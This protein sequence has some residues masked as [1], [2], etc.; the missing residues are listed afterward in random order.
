M[1]SADYSRFEAARAKRTR[2]LSQWLSRNPLS[3]F[4]DK[5]ALYP[6]RSLDGTIIRV[7]VGGAELRART[8]GEQIPS[9]PPLDPY[10]DPIED[11]QLH[12]LTPV[13]SFSPFPASIPLAS[14]DTQ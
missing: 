10:E 4:Y 11:E 1:N 6:R 7:R 14:I 13:E 5:T 2:K 9:L 8:S 12:F 3:A